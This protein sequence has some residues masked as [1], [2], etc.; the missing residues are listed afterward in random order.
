M[1]SE[2]TGSLLALER[3][4]LSVFVPAERNVSPLL[5]SRTHI[6]AHYCCCCRRRYF[7]DGENLG[8]LNDFREGDDPQEN[9]ALKNAD[10]FE[11]VESDLTFVGICGIKVRLLCVFK[12]PYSAH[13]PGANAI[14]C[15]AITAR[16]TTANQAVGCSF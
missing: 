14:R 13:K 11:E 3:I 5:D 8:N 10:K 2:W 12:T 6:S 15:H 9:N 7:Q 16:T 1:A 4:L